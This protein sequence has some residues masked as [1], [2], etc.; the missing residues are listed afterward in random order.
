[1]P[2]GNESYL[3]NTLEL[4]KGFIVD[5]KPVNKGRAVIGYGIR[6]EDFK[7]PENY[8]NATAKMFSNRIDEF[9]EKGF[10]KRLK[11]K[12]NK[13]KHFSITPIGIIYFCSN[14]KEIDFMVL[15]HVMSHLKYFYE[16][17]IPVDEISYI[18][19]I[20]DS[21]QKLQQLFKNDE[22]KLHSIFLSVFKDIGQEKYD[23]TL[24]IN[25]NYET[26]LGLKTP[27]II[28]Q[29]VDSEYRLIMDYSIDDVWT[30]NYY[31][32]TEKEFNYNF[33]KFVLKAFSFAVLE[34]ISH[35]L[36]SSDVGKTNTLKSKFNEIPLE[37]H[38]MALEFSDELRKSQNKI[39]VS[40]SKTNTNIRNFM[41]S[42]D[43]KTIHELREN[44][45]TKR[46]RKQW[47]TYLELLEKINRGK[48]AVKSKTRLKELMI[49]NKVCE[50]TEELDKLWQENERNIR[51]AFHEEVGIKGM[52]ERIFVKEIKEIKR[53][54]KELERKY[55]EF[56]KS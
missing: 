7:K 16:Q 2:L 55:E 5:S 3:E 45:E 1:V 56:L 15:N 11:H 33:S 36:M 17:G 54:N 29:I 20:K 10:V 14:L 8:S 35:S 41:K 4:L 48:I 28:Y 49:K 42:R 37:I 38:G 34:E 13:E 44:K 9:L 46:F 53:I 50:N 12:S 24:E 39:S 6:K 21:W 52:Y 18:Q 22:S 30:S 23:D 43:I 47:D 51:K 19:N 25:L 26:Y 40:V 27:V 31:V 32:S